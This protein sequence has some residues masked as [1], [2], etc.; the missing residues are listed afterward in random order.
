[1]DRG[2]LLNLPLR[3][4]PAVRFDGR[5]SPTPEA[6]LRWV[7]FARMGLRSSRGCPAIKRLAIRRPGL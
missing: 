7:L 5:R 1:M 4:I 2:L 6:P 3:A